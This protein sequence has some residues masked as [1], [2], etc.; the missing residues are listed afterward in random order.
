M[1]G[2]TT[3]K[4]IVWIG[5]GAGRQDKLC[6]EKDFKWVTGKLK[7]LGVW[8]SSD[9]MVS[10]VLFSWRNNLRSLSKGKQSLKWSDE[11]LVHASNND[12]HSSSEKH[13]FWHPIILTQQMSPVGWLHYKSSLTGGRDALPQRLLART[14]LKANYM[15][16][17]L[18]VEPSFFSSFNS[19]YAFT[20][21]QM[22]SLSRVLICYNVCINFDLH[23]MSAILAALALFQSK[24]K[25]FH[26]PFSRKR[27]K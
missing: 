23:Y 14:S 8:I 15:Q 3:R 13:M 17:I 24:I 18:V 22:S 27:C 25:E 26:L 7:A 6:P 1:C 10:I 4:Q 12:Y 2:L 21:L 5:A 9:P 11:K 19:T 20:K 16:W